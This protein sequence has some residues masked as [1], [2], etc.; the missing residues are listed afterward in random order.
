MDSQKLQK[1][2]STRLDLMNRLHLDLKQ[3]LS[4]KYEGIEVPLELNSNVTPLP[5]GYK[6]VAVKDIILD[7][8]HDD[9][10]EINIHVGKIKYEPI[11]R[12]YI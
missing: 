1:A 9:K 11:Q 2:E 6:G 10:T 12:F 7:G 4:K 8:F 3:I 5:E